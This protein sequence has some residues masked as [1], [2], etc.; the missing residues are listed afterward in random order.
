MV[1]RKTTIY[2]ISRKEL[3]KMVCMRENIKE[4]DIKFNSLS[5]TGL[6]IGV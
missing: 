3:I 2:N 6:R 5:S 1:V 4:E